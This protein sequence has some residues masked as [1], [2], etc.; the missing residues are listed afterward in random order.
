ML[1]ITI[2]SV[3]TAVGMAGRLHALFGDDV[4]ADIWRTL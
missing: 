3:L 2:V 1:E 4:L